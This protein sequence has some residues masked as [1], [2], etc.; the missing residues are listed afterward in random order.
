MLAAAGQAF[1]ELFTPPFRAVLWK[2]VGF[3]IALLALL[4]AA[5]SW[6]VRGRGAATIV[7]PLASARFT[8]FTDFPGAERDAS[9]SP[10]GKFV[11]FRSDRDG[12]FD[13][14]LGQAIADPGRRDEAIR[15]WD[16]APYARD[17]HP[18]EEHLAPLFVAAG[19][20]HGEPGRVTF[21]DVAMDVALSGYEFGAPA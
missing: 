19:A 1:Q 8:R 16:R 9:I 5:A 6:V 15:H 17:A 4:T 3:T 2:C 14:W 20:A 7:N 10:D 18:R 21:R 13:A 12:P 11:V